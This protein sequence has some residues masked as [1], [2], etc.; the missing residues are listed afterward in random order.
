MV[1]PMQTVLEAIISEHSKSKFRDFPG[2]PVVKTL[3]SSAR[4]A[5][6]I[7]GQRLRFHM[8]HSVAKQTKT[9]SKFFDILTYNLRIIHQLI[10]F[11]YVQQKNGWISTP[12]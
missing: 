4:G 3:P 2:S 6:L 5:G 10:I 9:E 8:M 11:F 12:R 1:Y 7:P